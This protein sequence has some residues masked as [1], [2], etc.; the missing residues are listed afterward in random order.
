M[1]PSG[2]SD[3]PD[4]EETEEPT[5]TTTPPAIAKTAVLRTYVPAAAATLNADYAVGSGGDSQR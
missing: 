2:R 3:H 1:A 4:R 5:M